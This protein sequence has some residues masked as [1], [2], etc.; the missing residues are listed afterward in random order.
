MLPPFFRYGSVLS[1]HFGP[2]SCTWQKREEEILTKG[3]WWFEFKAFHWWNITVWIENSQQD[4]RYVYIFSKF[5][6]LGW[7]KMIQYDY[8]KVVSS[9][10]VYYSILTFFFQRS[11]YISIQFPLHKPSEN[12]W[13]CYVLTETVYCSWLYSISLS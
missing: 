9:R 12:P 13:M 2:S 5:G 10:L 4:E 11:Q 3:R 1:Y 6:K 8:C 7:S